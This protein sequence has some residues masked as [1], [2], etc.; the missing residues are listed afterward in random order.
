MVI[1]KS[2]IPTFNH[3]LSTINQ[4]NPRL[5]LKSWFFSPIQPQASPETGTLPII[6]QL[7]I[8]RA[9]SD[10]LINI[11]QIVAE[12]FHSQEGLWGWA[13]PLFRMGIYEDLRH[14]LLFP[15]SR[16]ICLVAVDTATEDQ[17][18]M[19]TIEIGIRLIDSWTSANSAFPYLSNLAIHPSYRRLGLGS[20]LLIRCEQ[21]SL[22]WGF[23]DLY[24]HVLE[25]NHHAC[26]LYFKLAYQVHKIESPWD[27]LFF[28]RS[29]RIL[30]HKRIY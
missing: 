8:R 26:K 30:L 6:G 3:L 7:Q 15:M 25:N 20:S 27:L 28:S 17:K 11:A 13:F 1:K 18:I 9:T 23:Q 4:I 19:G 29:R 22:E 21:I 5:A 10:D 16:H 14:R 12:S 24:L 2:Q